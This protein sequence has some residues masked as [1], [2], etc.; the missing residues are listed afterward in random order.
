MVSGNL[1]VAGP[2]TLTLTAAT[3]GLTGTTTVNGGSLLGTAANIATPVALANGGNVTYTQ[4]VD[5]VLSYPVSGNGS[6]TKAGPET[7]TVA[8]QQL[9]Q[10][11][12]TISGGTLQLGS[13][14]YQPI[15]RYNF[16][17]GLGNGISNGAP[18]PTLAATATTES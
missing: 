8:T 7:L 12:T 2:S 10:G 17:G 15:I 11:A 1:N 6:L 5:D 18:F 9:Y 16:S 4:T 14:V 3:N 13:P